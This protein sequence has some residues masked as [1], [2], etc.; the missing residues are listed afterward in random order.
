MNGNFNPEEVALAINIGKVCY[1]QSGSDQPLTLA[2]IYEALPG[3]LPAQIDAMLQRLDGCR[4][5][6]LAIGVSVRS[7][8][9]GRS[10]SV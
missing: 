1:G 10:V 2:Q 5:L 9:S 8:P 7:E 3:V 4:L 6:R